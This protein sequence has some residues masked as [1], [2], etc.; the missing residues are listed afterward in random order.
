MMDAMTTIK[1]KTRKPCR[2]DPSAAESSR[3][4]QPKIARAAV[5]EK[6]NGVS[7]SQPKLL[8]AAAARRRKISGTLDNVFDK[9]NSTVVSC[10]ECQLC[11]CCFAVF[12]QQMSSMETKICGVSFT[13]SGR[14]RHQARTLTD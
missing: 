8:A 5:A 13:V 2:I 4:R 3:R 1:S 6:N 14:L 9:V 7:T 10:S 11:C 12:I